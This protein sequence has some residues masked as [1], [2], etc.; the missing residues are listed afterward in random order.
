[1]YQLNYNQLQNYLKFRSISMLLTLSFLKY[2]DT[3]PKQNS[4][5]LSYQML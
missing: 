2:F 1:M 5:E 4:K 3:L